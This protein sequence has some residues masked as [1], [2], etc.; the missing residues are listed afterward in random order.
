MDV[1]DLAWCPMNEFLATCSVDNTVNVWKI[2]DEQPGGGAN[3]VWQRVACL[4]GHKSHV[5]GITWDPVGKFLATQADDKSVIIWRTENWTQVKSSVWQRVG[6][7][8][9]NEQSI[10]VVR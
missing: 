7:R 6:F 8:V 10:C 1:T 2:P 5:K 3:P 4:T 9:R